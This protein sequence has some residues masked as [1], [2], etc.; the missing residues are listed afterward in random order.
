MSNVIQFRKPKENT[1]ILIRVSTIEEYRDTVLWLM[2][3]GN[4]PHC[5]QRPDGKYR[6]YVNKYGNDWADGENMMEACQAAIALWQSR[7]NS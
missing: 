2:D 6:F 4:D 1:P 3:N 5:F 7:E